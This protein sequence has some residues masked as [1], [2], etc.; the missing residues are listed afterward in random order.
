MNGR[1]AFPV[2]LC[3]VSYASVVV[4]AYAFSNVLWR[5]TT[6]GGHRRYPG[7]PGALRA[8]KGDSTRAENSAFR[9]YASPVQPAVAARPDSEAAAISRNVVDVP[10]AAERAGKTV[11][12]DAGSLKW[13]L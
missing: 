13:D 3:S 8:G 12:V 11:D 4:T 7:W 6:G 1:S 5:H 2:A 10:D 9:V